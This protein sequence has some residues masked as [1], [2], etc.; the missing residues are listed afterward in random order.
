MPG[1][2][3][4]AFAPS[5]RPVAP[6]CASALLRR[7]PAGPGQARWDHRMRLA[8]RSNR[9]A[10]PWYG[11]RNRTTPAVG[12]DHIRPFLDSRPECRGEERSTCSAHGRSR[13]RRSPRTNDVD[14]NE[15]SPNCPARK[16]T[17]RRIPHGRRVDSD[18]H[19]QERRCQ[20]DGAEG[21][22][23]RRGG[24]G[25]PAG[26]AD[27]SLAPG[28]PRPELERSQLTARTVTATG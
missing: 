21:R 1:R 11:I 9:I 20:A 5:R 8:H 18:P 23:R 10:L 22:T 19:N 17:A 27:F 16:G 3:P 2:W 25:G 7:Q 24:S 14:G 26:Y 12:A 28:L 15:P 13:L 4:A 6:R